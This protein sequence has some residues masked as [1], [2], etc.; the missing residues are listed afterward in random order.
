MGP[1][2]GIEAGMR[3][4]DDGAVW[5]VITHGTVLHKS[6]EYGVVYYLTTFPRTRATSRTRL[7]TWPS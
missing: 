4:H 2:D 7:R 1:F 5:E 6:T 3:W